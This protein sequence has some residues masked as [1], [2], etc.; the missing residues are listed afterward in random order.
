MNQHTQEIFIY[1][2]IKS[3]ITSY[4]FNAKDQAKSY[5]NA[6][7]VALIDMRVGETSY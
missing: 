3:L 6:I 7:D 4:K 5:A 1:K 2:N